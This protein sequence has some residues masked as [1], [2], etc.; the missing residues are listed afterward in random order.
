MENWPTYFG[1]SEGFRVQAYRG[2]RKI[3]IAYHNKNER[4]AGRSCTTTTT[5][6]Q[7]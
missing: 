2:K 7:K 5:R 1:N 4:E 3:R 6:A